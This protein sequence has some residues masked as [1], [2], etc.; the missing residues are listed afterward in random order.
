MQKAVILAVLPL[1]LAGPSVATD[2]LP[3]RLG[4]EAIIEPAADGDLICAL[5]LTDLESGKVV[6]AP[7]LRFSDDQPG[8][9]RIGSADGTNG[10]GVDVVTDR[11]QSSVRLTIS[12]I[13]ESVEKIVHQMSVRQR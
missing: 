1:L 8:K 9:L 3:E 10:W 13:R 4:V 5:K 6:A 12:V 2:L 11:E 7:S